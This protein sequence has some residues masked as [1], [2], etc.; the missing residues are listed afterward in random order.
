MTRYVASRELHIVFS[1]SLAFDDHPHLNEQLK[2]L[3]GVIPQACHE[4]RRGPIVGG[5]EGICA[6]CKEH[7]ND[8]V[9]SPLSGN[10]KDST[11]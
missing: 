9:F 7:L 2:T 1:R 6:H 5:K 3:C 8:L 10:K 11:F 4:Q